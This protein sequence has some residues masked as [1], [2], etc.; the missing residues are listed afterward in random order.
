MPYFST[1]DGCRL[2]YEAVG[3]N[4][5]KPVVTFLNGTTQTTVHWTGQVRCLRERYGILLYDARA[6]GRSDLGRKPLGIHIHAADLAA[7]LQYLG[8]PKTHLVGMSHG[9][10]V[11]LELAVRYPHH[12]ARLVLCS[13]TAIPSRRTRSLLRQWR[14]ILATS[15]MEAAAWAM[16]PSVMGE[17]YLTE[18]LNMLPKIVRAM[19]SR[20]RPESLL[21]HFD[22]MSGYPPLSC[23]VALAGL[24]VL[25]VSGE[26]DPLV[27]RRDARNLADRFDGKHVSIPDTGHTI[28]IEA[29]ERLNRELEVF[30]GLEDDGKT[31]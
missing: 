20:N 19:A 16:L 6:Q 26:Q 9:A 12:V 8:L 28:Q 25:V 13:A 18:N 31:G 1:E 2:Y 11:A 3:I 7:L 22:A 5:A 24:P 4:T 27:S 10:R 15:G 21:A 17:A 29:P 30:L 23:S 14:D